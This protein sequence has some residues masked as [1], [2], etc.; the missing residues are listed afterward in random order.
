MGS[1]QVEGKAKELLLYAVVGGIATLVEWACFWLLSHVMH[2][3]PATCLAFAISTFANWLAG[4]AILFGE[5][6]RGVAVELAQIYGASIA[7]LL[8]NLAI[9]WVAIELFGMHEMVGKMLATAIVF[10]WNYL[11][12]KLY[13]Y[14][15]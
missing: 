3:V 10:F 15:R 13:I 2:Y 11:I 8:M 5:S 7:G 6:S 1:V 4:R 9:M 14:R 12:R